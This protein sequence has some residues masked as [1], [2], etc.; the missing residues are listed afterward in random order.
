MCL[1][2][3]AQVLGELLGRVSHAPVSIGGGGEGLPFGIGGGVR[4]SLI[5]FAGPRH[6]AKL[7]F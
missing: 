2:F 4:G 1:S 6:G 7:L 5:E 3:R